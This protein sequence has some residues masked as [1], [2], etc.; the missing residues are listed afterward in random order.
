MG[1]S[2]LSLIEILYYV[3]LRVACIQIKARKTRKVADEDPV[4]GINIGFKSQ[5]GEGRQ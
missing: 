5:D 2:L 1:V 3:T 4:T